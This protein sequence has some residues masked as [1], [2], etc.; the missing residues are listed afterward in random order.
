MKSGVAAKTSEIASSGWSNAGAISETGCTTVVARP[1]ATRPAAASA[2]STTGDA[3][4]VRVSA[5]ITSA[6]GSAAAAASNGAAIPPTT[7][8]K[9]AG[10]GAGE[11]PAALDP[12]GGAGAE[13]RAGVVAAV[14]ILAGTA[15]SESTTFRILGELPAVLASLLATDETVD[16]TPLRR[17][18]VPCWVLASAAGAE[19]ESQATAAAPAIS[20][21]RS[22]R[23]KDRDSTVLTMLDTPRLA[24]NSTIFYS[25]G[26]IQSESPDPWENNSCDSTKPFGEHLRDAFRSGYMPSADVIWVADAQLRSDAVEKTHGV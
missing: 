22:G 17:V 16:E 25:V 7:G 20:T 24:N 9:T 11:V 13:T 19:K 1:S 26:L 23:N 10:A 2:D 14:G 6:E 5:G 4:R 3:T 18:S 21:G 8:D 12:A 15:A